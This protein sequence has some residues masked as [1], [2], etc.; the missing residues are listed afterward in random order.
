MKEEPPRAGE[1]VPSRSSWGKFFRCP[2]FLSSPTLHR[3]R[4]ARGIS[5]WGAQCVQPKLPRPLGFPTVR[6]FLCLLPCYSP[7]CCCA[8]RSSVL[9]AKK[10]K[11]T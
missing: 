6:V 11:G 1:N 10:K 2:F 5:T 4:S 9:L 7:L 8:A 3:R